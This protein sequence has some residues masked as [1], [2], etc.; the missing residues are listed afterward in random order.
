M[1]TPVSAAW[2]K[3]AMT[4][5]TD[6]TNAFRRSLITTAAPP[7]SGTKPTSLPGTTST[8]RKPAAAT[9]PTSLPGTTST[10]RKPAAATTRLATTSPIVQG[11]EPNDARAA[12]SPSLEMCDAIIDA[13]SPPTIRVTAT[14]IQPILVGDSADLDGTAAMQQ[15]H[16]LEGEAFDDAVA[17]SLTSDH[18]LSLPSHSFDDLHRLLAKEYAPLDNEEAALDNRAHHTLSGYESDE[19]FHFDSALLSP[20]RSIVLDAAYEIVSDMTTDGSDSTEELR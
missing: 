8:A 9:K 16:H 15:H 19:P 4:T 11:Q 13:Q 12:F 20:K 2:D 18:F 3:S 10:A 1:M 17:A 6:Q 5:V 7:P 14:S